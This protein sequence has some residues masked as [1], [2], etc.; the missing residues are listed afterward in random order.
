M[1]LAFL[2]PLYERPGPWSSVYVDLSAHAEDTHAEDTPHQRHLTAEATARDLKGQGA[3]EAV[4][5]CG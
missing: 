3:D 2:T 4:R 5:P 1:D